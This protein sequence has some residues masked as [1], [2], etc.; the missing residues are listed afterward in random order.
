MNIVWSKSK[1]LARGRNTAELVRG[2]GGLEF[3]SLDL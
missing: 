3:K 2:K 1:E